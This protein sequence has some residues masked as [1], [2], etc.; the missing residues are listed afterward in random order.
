MQ[1]ES[2]T[3]IR[4]FRVVCVVRV[5][6]K[7]QLERGRRCERGQRGRKCCVPQ[8]FRQQRALA[9][10]SH[11]SSRILVEVQ[12]TETTVAMAYQDSGAMHLTTPHSR[13]PTDI[14]GAMHLAIC[15]LL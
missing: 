2:S 13:G 14:R 7:P 6:K 1:E 11:D 15:P 3:A 9:P 4:V 12:R 5:P 8:R 10:D